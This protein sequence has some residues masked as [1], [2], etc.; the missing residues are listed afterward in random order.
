[1]AFALDGYQPPAD[2]LLARRPWLTNASSW[3]ASTGPDDEYDVDDR[4]VWPIGNGY[5]FAHAGLAAPFNRLQGLVGPSYQTEGVHRP[6]GAFGDCWAELR[7]GLK[8]VTL[9]HDHIWR[10]RE[11]GVLV[12]VAYR[13]GMALTTI[14]FAHPDRGGRGSHRGDVVQG[15]CA[16]RR[17]DRGSARVRR[18][19]EFAS[20]DSVSS[21][22]VHGGGGGWLTG[23]RRGQVFA[24]AALPP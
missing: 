18:A 17:R 4:G 11:S 8:P 20:G 13:H 16:H 9:P 15:R 22:T 7:V 23:A 2:S 12:T 6:S 19:R 21:R 3:C 1:M 5:V 10:P 14:D 24:V